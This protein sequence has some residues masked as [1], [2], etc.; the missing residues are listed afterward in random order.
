M[1]YALVNVAQ[2]RSK[3][4]KFILCGTCLDDL[5]KGF[6]LVHE[7]FHQA[8]AKQARQTMS[9]ALVVCKY[10]IIAFNLPC[11]TTVTTAA[12]LLWLL[13]YNCLWW[14]SEMIRITR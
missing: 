12:L 5:N 14:W 1:K 7:V 11:A 4:T 8:T 2:Q 3:K 10:V 9:M 13:N 6:C